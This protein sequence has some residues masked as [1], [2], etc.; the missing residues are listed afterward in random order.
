M[1][2]LFKNNASTKLASSITNSATS[3]SVVAGTGDLFPSPVAPDYFL[4]TIVDDLGNKEIVK[5]TARSVD[6]FT[7]VRGQEGT[8][9]RAFN[10][11][12]LVENR[13]TAGALQELLNVTYA[14]D[15]EVAAGVVSTKAVAPSTLDSANVAHAVVSGSC[16]GNA[17]TASDMAAGHALAGATTISEI[18]ARLSDTVAATT[19]MRDVFA[20]CIVEWESTTIPVLADGLPLG[21]ELNGDIASLTLVPR[22]LRKWCGAGNNATAP[23]WYRCN[24]S[25]VRDAA[26]GYIKLQDRRGEFSRGWDHGRGVDAGRNLSTLQGDAIRNIT[27]E[28]GYTS[29]GG[30]LQQAGYIANGV[31]K[32]GTGTSYRPI[33][34]TYAGYTLAFDASRVV[35]TASE[36]RPR[37][38]STMYVVII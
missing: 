15:A 9:A 14:S 24:A 16:T 37:N 19:L 22:L 8:T 33:G 38:I 30:L 20:G 3:M 4:C 10:A 21:V 35:P 31:F 13:L 28:A 29:V 25:G 17:A 34:D 12:S 18:R 5:V 6:T 32:A 23:A 26:G 2:I 27:G 11:N 7:I 36:N 1:A